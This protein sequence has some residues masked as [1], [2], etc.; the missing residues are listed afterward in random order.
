MISLQSTAFAMRKTHPVEP[1]Y[2]AENSNRQERQGYKE[3][4]CFWTD[5]NIMVTSNADIPLDETTMF[6]IR[7]AQLFDRNNKIDSLL[8][9]FA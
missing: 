2:S 3:T 6:A 9:K 7:L 1:V 8:K 4:E 5:G